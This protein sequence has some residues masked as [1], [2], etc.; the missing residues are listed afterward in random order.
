MRGGGVACWRGGVGPAL[1]P[2]PRAQSKS[3]GAGMGQQAPAASVH[4]P[5]ASYRYAT[6]FKPQGAVRQTSSPPSSSR[7]NAPSSLWR[8]RNCRTGGSPSAARTSPAFPAGSA[9]DCS[10][11]PPT[12]AR[13][14][15]WSSID[16]APTTRAPLRG[17]MPGEGPPVGPPPLPAPAPP[18]SSSRDPPPL[19][20]GR[21]PCGLGGAGWRGW[22]GG[23]G[24]GQRGQHKG[25][26]PL[27]ITPRPALSAKAGGH[28]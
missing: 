17:P 1:S 13:S 11:P 6:P 8:L 15:S 16:S 20:L 26:L 2:L 19:C 23:R 9:P 27:D 28:R 5:T 7:T 25:H 14:P 3:W 22:G 10:A 21:L 18:P 12:A 4:V 24:K